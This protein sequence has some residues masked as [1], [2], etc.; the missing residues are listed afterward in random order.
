MYIELRSINRIGDGG[1]EIV[2]P[3]DIIRYLEFDNSVALLLK[4]ENNRNHLVSVKF[5]FNPNEF[6][7]AWNFVYKSQILYLIKHIEEGKE[8]IKIKT[9]DDMIFILDPDTGNIIFESQ[10]KG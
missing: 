6:Y 8:Y 3:S 2:L 1:N 9:W 5:K 10:T 7:I 4:S